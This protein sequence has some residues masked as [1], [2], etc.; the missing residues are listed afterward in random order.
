[1]SLARRKNNFRI[2]KNRRLHRSLKLAGGSPLEAL[3]KPTERKN[4]QSSGRKASKLVSTQI[5]RR[6]RSQDRKVAGS[7]SGSTSIRKCLEEMRK[8]EN[9]RLRSSMQENVLKRARKEMSYGQFSKVKNMV[10]LQL[11]LGQS[12]AFFGG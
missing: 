5:Q 4:V 11:N 9:F 6:A 7:R 12:K 2:N 1:M 3:I 8:R 10:T